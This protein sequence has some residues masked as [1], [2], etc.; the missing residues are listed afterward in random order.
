MFLI[1]KYSINDPWDVLF[2]QD[3]YKK[4]LN[5]NNLNSWLDDYVEHNDHF[6]TMPNLLIYG[7]EGCGKCS[8]INLLLKRLYGKGFK[9]LNVKYYING[10]GSNN[11]EVE[12][13]QSL[14]HI[15][16][17]PTNTGLDKYLVQ[18]VIKKYASA[19]I[20]GFETNNK[21]KIIWIHNIDNLSYYAQTAL[22]CIM[23]K[24]YKVCK[25][26][27]SGK[28]LSKVI[29][30]LRSRC[31][32][33]RLPQPNN[34]DIMRTILNISYKEDKL[35][36]FK[37]YADIIQKCDNN[38]KLAIIYLEVKANNFEIEVSWKLHVKKIVK[39]LHQILLNNIKQSDISDIRD[40][41]YKIFITN[42]N[43]TEIIKELLQQILVSLK[44]YNLSYEIINI[45]T[46][47]ENSLAN[48]KRSIIHLEAFIFNI[49][50]FLYKKYNM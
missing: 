18:E 26:I 2:H 40:I 17:I 29:E 20:L 13:P 49:L 24:Y 3:I 4:L 1:D 42:I 14:N 38:I 45:C 12:I 10:Y 48:G 27:L 25:F 44:D 32:N 35:L 46:K 36:S 16:I 9:T 19:N 43:G 6:N 47:Y 21:F 23:E 31:L 7:N 39:I 5:L 30:P 22:R 33:I 37:D 34:Q 8:I 50:D 11:I 15:Q 28:Q 41:L